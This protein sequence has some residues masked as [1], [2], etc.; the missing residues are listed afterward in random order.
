MHIVTT[1]VHHTL[2][3]RAERYLVLL[4]DGECIDV[5]AQHHA[6]TKVATL[7]LDG[8]EH[9][10]AGNLTAGDALGL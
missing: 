2:E 6:T 4:F 7:A 1:G 3:L 5:G 9:S 10:C 8:G